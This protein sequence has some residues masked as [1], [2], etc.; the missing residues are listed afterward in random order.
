MRRHIPL[1]QRSALEIRQQAE[2]Y[3]EMASSA[4][5][6]EAKQG[7]EMLAVRFAALAEQRQAQIVGVAK[8]LRIDRGPVERIG[9]T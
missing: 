6:A 8:V 2:R 4:R 7:L 9:G 3:S 5:T 1:S